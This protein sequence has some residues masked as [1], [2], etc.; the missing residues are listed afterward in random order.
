[1]ALDTRDI[2][3]NKMKSCFHGTYILV[4]AGNKQ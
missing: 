4:E 3:M 1:M 2:E